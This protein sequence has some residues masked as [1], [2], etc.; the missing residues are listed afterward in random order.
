MVCEM[1]NG[2]CGFR[3]PRMGDFQEAVNRRPLT[4]RADGE[5]RGVGTG[6]ADKSKEDYWY[7]SRRCRMWTMSTTFS[8]SYTW[9]MTR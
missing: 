2:E 8:L 9:K 5:F 1:W 3:I 6:C 7:A 4:T